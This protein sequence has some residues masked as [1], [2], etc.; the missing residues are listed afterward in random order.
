MKKITSCL[1]FNNNAEEA[2]KLYTSIFFNSKIGKTLR[3][4]ESGAQASGQKKDAVMTIEFDIEDRTILALNGGPHFKFTPS[5]SYFV[6]CR[7]EAEISRLW[8]ALST[9]GQVR[10]KLDKYPWAEQYA[11]TADKF[12]VEWQLILS[13]QKRKIAPAFLFVDKLFGK[14]EEAIRFYSSVF[15]NSKIEFLAKDEKT[16]SISHGVFTL[17]DEP[18][19]LMEGQGKY[20][21]EFTNAFSLVVNCDSQQEIDHYWLKLSEGGSVEQCGWLKDKYGVSWQIVPRILGSLMQDP[22][23]AEKVMKAILQMQKLDLKTLEK[24]AN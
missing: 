14:G 9:D 17:E 3:Y 11:W 22:T 24:A 7:T 8:K 19:V 6:W 21:Y 4:G 18:F 23:K 16:K 15:K 1:W 20:S 2:V 12:G 10:M 5:L 13:E